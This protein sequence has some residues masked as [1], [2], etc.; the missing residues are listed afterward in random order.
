MGKR[1]EYDPE[2]VG[3]NLKRLREERGYTVEEIR[4]YLCL[5]SVQAVY[6]YENG[7]SY[8]SAD[9][10]LALMELYDV[11]VQ[12]IVEPRRMDRI[13]QAALLLSHQTKREKWAERRYWSGIAENVFVVLC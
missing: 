12:D 11:R 7:K 13:R 9:A 8:P 1:R 5:G 10:L 4:E 3:Q 6:K 2:V